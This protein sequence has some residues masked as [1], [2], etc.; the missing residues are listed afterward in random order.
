LARYVSAITGVDVEV[1]LSVK[2]VAFSSFHHMN[3]T[4]SR[5]DEGIGVVSREYTRC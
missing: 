5:G 4:H 2:S 3:L 1:Y